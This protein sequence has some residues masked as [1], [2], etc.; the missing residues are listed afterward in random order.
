MIISVD[1]DG[2]VI[3]AQE[4][5]PSMRAGAREGLLALKRAGHVLILSSCRANMAL[6]ADWR[7]N[8]LWTSG[9]VPF[10]EESWAE[11]RDHWEAAYQEMLAF[12]DKEL[13]GVFDAVDPGMQGKVLAD[14]YLDARAF[15]MGNS[16]WRDVGMMLGESAVARGRG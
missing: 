5:A 3:D 11:G 6:R 10:V 7:L 4:G 9:A 2:V 16:G 8:P 13:P 1:F 14:F 12:V 15:R